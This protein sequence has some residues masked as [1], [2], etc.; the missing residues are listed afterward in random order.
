[1]DDFLLDA[2]K[3]NYA[4]NSIEDLQQQLSVL[5]QVKVSESKAEHISATFEFRPNAVF[6]VPENENDGADAGQNIDLVPARSSAVTPDAVAS[7]NGLARP[8]PTDEPV[9]RATREI[10][11]QDALLNQ[12][13]DDP[14]LQKAVAKLIITCLGAADD[15]SWMVRSVSRGPSG[16]TFQYICRNSRQA[17]QRQNS[18]TAAKVLVGESSG[19]DGQDPVNLGEKFSVGLFV[20]RVL[21]TFS[22][23][24]PAFDCRGSVIVAFARNSRLITVKLDHTPFHKTVADLLELY[25]PPPPPARTEQARRKTGNGKKRK[26]PALEAAE[27]GAEVVNGETVEGPSQAK[28]KRKKSVNPDDQAVQDQQKAKPKKSRKSSAKN[29]AQHDDANGQQDLALLNLSPSEAARRRDQAVR[30]LAEHGIDAK[31]LSAEQFDIFANQ[32]PDLQN[33][34]LAMLVRYGAERLRIVHPNKDDGSSAPSSAEPAA[35]AGSTPM[36]KSTRKSRLNEDGTPKM[37]R[38]RGSCQACR[39]NK[40]KVSRHCGC[41]DELHCQLTMGS[42]QKQSR[43]ALN[44]SRLVLR[45]TIRHKRR[46]SLYTNPPKWSSS[47]LK[48]SPRRCRPPSTLRLQAVRLS[49]PKL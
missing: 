5:R 17:W 22:A 19:Q 6:H 9:S 49:S 48:S 24:R 12:P 43:N 47:S 16:W 15:S 2:P 32:S 33:E 45:A 29:T 11:A 23:A 13:A 40:R 1:M 46:G 26:T 44:V 10:R 35:V 30:K 28:K 39:D 36:R 20:P 8:A 3:S 27:A 42:A 41:H 21:L 4:C 25:K 7:D 37:K 31:T 34:S 18:K 14:T 38:T